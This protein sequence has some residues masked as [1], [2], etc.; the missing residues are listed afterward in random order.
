MQNLVK[1]ICQ[2]PIVFEKPSILSEKFKT[3]TS[4]YNSIFFA[5][6][7][8]TFCTYQCLKEGTWDFLFCLYLM[9]IANIKEDQVST[10]S[11][12]TFLLITLDLDKIKKN[13][14]QPFVDITK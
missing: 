4:S 2:S 6:T 12:F 1:K 11:F 3:L 9:L 8:R 5:E 14:E 10:H 7:L 13:P